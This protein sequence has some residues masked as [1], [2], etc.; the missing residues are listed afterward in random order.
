[1]ALALLWPRCCAAPPVRIT[2]PVRLVAERAGL[3]S[4]CGGTDSF[5]C[6]TV[7]HRVRG[8]KRV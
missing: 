8:P 5:S 6:G 4:H 1:M 7:G 2:S 3:P